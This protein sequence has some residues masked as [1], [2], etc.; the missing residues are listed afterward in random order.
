MKSL[1]LFSLLLIS[2][3][4]VTH[5]QDSARIYL[6]MNFEAVDNNKDAVIIRDALI[7]NDR[8]YIADQYVD[9][10]KIMK[11]EYSSVD[12]WI[13]DGP[14]I[15]YD[16]KGRKYAEGNFRNGSMDGRWI[17]YNSTGTDT[18]VYKKEWIDIVK[19]GALLKYDGEI[20]IPDE[21]LYN[22]LLDKIHFPPRYLL[23]C[24]SRSEM[25]HLSVSKNREIN[26]APF[27]RRLENDFSYELYRILMETPD[28]LIYEGY[29]RKN[30]HYTATVNYTCPGEFI[31][32]TSNPCNSP[33][34]VF[35]EE[36]AMFQ[37]GTLE[38]FRTWVQKNLIY[39]EQ[40]VINGE[41][42]R[43]TFQFTVTS[44]GKV[45][46]LK[47]L[48]SSG[49]PLLDK[50]AIRVVRDSPLWLPAKQGGKEVNQQFVMPVIF[51][52]R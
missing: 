1:S 41:Y 3:I 42:G 36:Q 7:K 21:D 27:F 25:F 52:L 19:K 12:P 22:Y 28:S 24:I 44:S 29:N 15:Y 5:A 51:Q 4:A 14:F 18:V 31:Q 32:L 34:F 8:Y 23:D 33:A 30:I 9:G 46:C 6:N 43:I 17:Y 20:K 48:R 45:D 26:I 47:I 10:R 50:E 13:E 39:P 40:S 35:V 11:G 38:N 2:G 16:H 49:Y 37:G